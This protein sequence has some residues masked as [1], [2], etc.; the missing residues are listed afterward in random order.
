MIRAALMTLL[1]FLVAVDFL[2]IGVNDVVVLFLFR[3]SVCSG[4]S[5]ARIGSAL[6]ADAFLVHG[7]AKLH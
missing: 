2:E 4:R 7:L 1:V 3:S 5:L 6:R